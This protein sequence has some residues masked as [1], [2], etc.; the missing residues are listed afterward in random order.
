MNR[1]RRWGLSALLGVAGLL[2][3]GPVRSDAEVILQYFGTNWRE[4]AMKMPELAEVGYGALWLPPPTKGSG[5]LSVGYDLWDPFDL[6]GKDQRNTVRTRYGTEADLAYLIRVAHRHGIRVYFDNIMNHRAFDVPGFNEYTPIDIYPGMVPEDFHLR[7]TSD[8]FYRKWD[9]IA[10][11]GDTW[12]IQYRNFSDLIDI[13]QET[14]DNGNFGASEGSHVPKIKLVRHPN[15]P[16]YYC[17]APGTNAYQAVYVGFGSTNITSAMVTNAANAWLY[18]EDVNAYL[19][20]AVRWLVDRTKV[21]GLRLDAVKHVPDYFFGQQNGGGKDGSNAGYLGQAQEQYN[22]TR[23]FSDWN[24]H[25]D[26]VFSTEVARDDLMMFGEHLGEPPGYG[27]YIDAGMRLVDSQLHGYLNGNLGQGWG[28]LDGLQY[29]GGRGFS[30]G[31]GVPYVKSHDDDYSTRPEL[32]FGLILTRQ[33]LPTVYT[34]GNYQAETLGES[35]G[36]F[37]RHANIAFLGQFSDPRIPNLVYI[38]EH[39]ARDQHW[40]RLGDADVVAY[41]RVDKRE[42]PSMGDADGAVLFFVLNDNYSAGAYREIDT[43]FPVGA[44]LWQYSA[45]GGGFYYVVPADRKIKVITPPGGYFAFSWR[46][47]EDS[48]LWSGAGGR[49]LTIYDDGREAGWV[50]YK[51]KDGP[52]GDPAFN[53][54]GVA[55]TNNADFTYTAFVPRVTQGTNLS[56]VARV[57]GSAFNVLL[58]LDGGI[59]LNGTT[60]PLGDLRDHPPGLNP[61]GSNSAES[62]DMYLGYEQAQFH[63]R[64]WREKFAARNTVSNNVI[65]SAGAE[66][67]ATTLG[68]TGAVF[69]VNAGVTGRDSEDNTADWAYHDPVV[70]NDQGQAQFTPSPAVAT[71]TDITVWLKTGYTTQVN[72]VFAYYTATGASYPEGAGGVGVGETRVAELFFDHHDSGDV[73]VDWWKGTLPPLPA[74]TVLRYKIGAYKQQGFAGAGWSVPF[75]NDA[76]SIATKKSMLGVWQLTNINAKTVA[77]RPHNDYGAFQT[78]LEDG[79]HVVRARAFLERSGR[80]AIYN[81]FVQPFYYDVST[82]T[83]VVVYPAENDTL[84]QNEYGVV[85]RTD[86][87]VTEVWYNLADAD[88]AND[89]S[90]TGLF[91][92]N[93][94][95]TNELGG[96]VTSWQ[97]ASAV[98]ASLNINS[99][100]PNEWRFSYRNIPSGNSNATIRVRLLELSSSTNM[101]LTDAT[102]HF[103]TLERH[104][105]TDGP[106]Q[107]LFFDWPGE[108]GAVVEA[109]WQVHVHFSKTLGD[110]IGDDTLRERFLVTVDGAAVGRDLYQITRDYNGSEGRLT[111]AFP[112]VFNGDLDGLHHIKVTHETGGGVTLEAS[113]FVRTR[114]A[115]VDAHIDIVQPPE[116]D[117]DGKPYEIVLPDVG[118]PSPEQRQFTIRVETDLTAQQVWLQFTN[119]VG[120]TVPLPETTNAL[121]ARVAVVNGSAAVSGV[122]FMLSGTV[123]V[124]ASNTVLT[125]VGTAFTQELTNGLALRIGTNVVTVSQVQSAVTLVLTEPYAGASASNVVAHLQPSFDTSLV[126]GDRLLIGGQVVAV[127]AI[128]SSSNLTLRAPY[129]GATA[130]GLTAWRLDGNPEVSNGRMYW[131]FLWTGMTAGKFTFYA[132]VNTNAPTTA[133]VSGY[134][135]RNT[136]VILR[137]MVSNNE[138]DLD[139]DD[140]GIYDESEN[141]PKGLPTGNSEEWTSGDVHVWQI[142]GR[143]APLLPDSDGDDLPDGLELGWRAPI[144]T[145]HT[146]PF[147]DTDGDGFT[148]FRGDLDPPFYNTVPD[149]SGLPEYVFNDSRTKMIH[150]SLTDANNRDSDYDGIPDGIED[151]NRNGWA[152][153]DGKALQPTT[154]NPAADRPNDNDW[155][156]GKWDAGWAV[157]AGRETSP[158]KAD[159]DEDGAGDGYGEDVNFNGWIDGDSNSN[160]VWQGGELWQET[161]PLNPDTDGD[162]LPD[163]WEK[164]FGLSPWDDGIIGHTNRQTG[165]VIADG[166]NG[167]TGNPDGDVTV[168]A[169]VTNQYTN[170][171][172]FQNGTNPMQFNSLDPAPAGGLM[173]GSG[174]V[175]G[176][177]GEMTVNQDF[178]DWKWQDCLVLDEY[179]G[180]GANNQQGDLFLGWDGWDSSRDIVAFYARDGGDIGVGD[181]KFYFRVDFQDLRANAEDGNLDLYVVIDTGNPGSGEMNLPDEVDTLT[182]NRWEAVVAVYGYNSGRVYVDQ[183]RNNNTTGEGQSLTAAGVVGRD[184]N[185]ANGFISAHYDATLDAVEFSISRQA[186]RDAGWNG[187]GATNFNYQVFT[188]KDG[189][190]NSPLGAGDIGGRNDVRDTIYDDH[191]AEDYWQAQAGIE[192]TLRSW[193]SGNS[194][195]G[196]AKVTVLVHGNQ[197]VHPGSVMQGLVNTGA[198][199]GYYRPL[200][201]HELF[202]KPLALHVTPTLASA[203]EWAAVDPAAG[204]PWRD[205][206][207]L[208]R[209]LGRLLATNIVHLMG[210]TFSDH[211][212]PYFSTTFN[213]DNDDL[214]REVLGSIYGASL[215]PANSVFWTPE[216][217]LDADVFAKIGAMGYAAT[218]LDQDTHLWNWFGRTESLVEGA[219]RINEINGIKC[220]VINAIP[221]ASLFLGEDGGLDLSLRSMLNRK[222]RSWAQDQVVTLF[223]NWEAFTD[224]AKADAYDRN[225]RWL[226]NHP[227]TEVVTHQQILRGEVDLDGDGDGDSWGWV[228]RGSVA[229]KAKQGHNWLNHATT[230]NF[231]NW[232]LGSGLEESLYGKRFEIRPGT[233]TLLTYGMD[234]IGDGVA[235]YG[236]DAVAAT[237]EPGLK[238]LARATLHASVFQTAFHSES[239]H[240]LRRYSTGEYMAPASGYNGLAGFAVNAQGQT[241]FTAVYE[242]LAPFAAAAYPHGE[243]V[244]MSGDYDLDGEAEY[245]LYN[246]RLCALFERLGGRLIGAWARDASEGDVYQVAGNFVGNAGTYNEAEGVSNVE[247]GG[248]VVAHRTSL[249]KDWWVA[250]STNSGTS[251]YVNDLYAVAAVSN[252]WRF[253][254]SDGKIQKTIAL[255][256]KSEI[257]EVSYVVG[258]DL[259]GKTLYIRNGLSLNLYDLLLHGQRALTG[260]SGA[261]GIAMLLSTNYN[262]T[263]S[264]M[265][266]Y[267][268][269]GHN[270]WLNMGAVDDNPGQGVAFDTVNMRNQPL[271]HQ[272]ELQGSNTF[273]FAIGFEVRASDWDV[274][275]VPNT[276]EDQ[277]PFL[278]PANGGDGALDYDG[279]GI[280]NAGEYV[281]GTDPDDRADVWGVASASN[282]ISGFRV[283]FEAHPGRDYA[284]W[285]EKRGLVV[286]VWSNATPEGISVAAD[287]VY[288]W[289]DDGSRTGGHP[290][291]STQRYYRVEVALP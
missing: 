119:S 37:P 134:A 235:G 80:A 98:T 117:S 160:R 56:V 169:G 191:V 260:F 252:G 12:Q 30:A 138:A 44:N 81:T 140:D 70:N 255:V 164:Q 15:N 106:A 22:L 247:P 113:R 50:S 242:Q 250:T 100:H 125:G 212:L 195:A 26:S 187:T 132:F 45:A 290:S 133:T 278:D 170:A 232:Y 173:I 243:T 162:T 238:K 180:D 141:T 64:Q 271:T 94:Q 63:H 286:P 196:R 220:F 116:F 136:T 147:M 130:S 197:A 150:G 194:R 222:A 68:A 66:T 179:E 284:V 135:I 91:E 29:A 42:K 86:L 21:D 123:T 279:D 8:G 23:G 33:G 277:Y 266:R 225:L 210:S 69:V 72:R 41:E 192:N 157:H 285:Y 226:A 167:A 223:S 257:F 202:G 65:G 253:T 109:G 89:D 121:P 51:R 104:V 175:L 272:F 129:A 73:A 280:N 27:G 263:V 84:G 152:D 282:S 172:E 83:G 217:L 182:L 35:G 275:G 268:D 95:A 59:D 2:A 151:R 99:P 111:F 87:T 128:G 274:D 237:T 85:V 193:I 7:V 75:P 206:P 124:A 17:Y 90:A 221:T 93:G 291:F 79:F 11:W 67:Y 108:D 102:G 159:T 184:Q 248:A 88:P 5:G 174:P 259:S 60:H 153:G 14:P 258:G 265:I 101:S 77:H 126:P 183:D 262:K 245:L 142:F 57:D 112:N 13:A 251:Q 61:N 241:R 181:G 249:L 156:D 82:P 3:L 92:G 270:A 155:P 52:D 96:L 246:D 71:N 188:T 107:R 208:N 47:P 97:R 122:E 55:D 215:S 9:N 38:H 198:G 24:N 43:A 165:A 281:A 224:T 214:A 25:R 145:N 131:H 127:S 1:L 264:A 207:A 62:V 10:N 261:G 144:N 18:E 16:D 239:E 240:D 154:G 204:K 20:R 46:S 6:G 244:A 201:A 219:Y 139:D 161:D 34:D 276:M 236:M 31:Q 213:A 227:W 185:A 176:T 148:N 186:L 163:G 230:E 288:T 53:P 103:T 254:S 199:A 283:S 105:K 36:A 166:R 120:T 171:E 49:P 269:P 115:D 231:D 114:A 190:Q 76:Y 177:L 256:P 40:A 218:V 74:G 146:N 158:G 205:G 229:G 233:N 39:F 209:R 228:A 58:K 4:L 216:R 287:Q 137:E 203:L 78:G 28:T 143:T 110:G 48:E 234:S 118:S 32:Q 149:N 189:T 19:I 200:D 289:Q 54:Y 267:A 168:T 178:T 211:M 273:H